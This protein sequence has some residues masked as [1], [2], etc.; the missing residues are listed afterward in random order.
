MWRPVSARLSGN[1]YRSV[2]PTRCNG[3][4]CGGG[5][6]FL[7]AVLAAL[8]MTFCVQWTG[9]QE[10]EPKDATPS[11][12]E[13][14]AWK[15]V[16]HD[17]FGGTELDESKWVH[18]AEGKRRIGWWSRN[19]VSVDGNGHLVI[20][21]KKEDGKYLDACIATQGKFEHS[22]GFYVARIQL[23][24]QQGHWPGFWISGPGVEKVGSQG[25]DGCEIDI[26]EKASLDDRVYHNLHWDGY[27]KDHKTK[28]SVVRVPGV[29]EGFHIFA[30]W[31]K[32]DEYVFYVDGKETWRTQAGRVCQ[33]PQFILLSDEVGSWAGNIAHAKLPDRFVVDYVR[34]YDL[35]EK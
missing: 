4:A 26:M 15:L 7:E 32:P 21:T 20:E 17:E 27:G 5:K 23:Q 22:F 13:G 8:A 2:T 3:W 14:K 25:R 34:V 35:V 10:I 33:T 11:A 31:W 9:A 30:L 29:M 19:A 28:G 18:Y 1:R 12:P 6:H 16:W 24:K